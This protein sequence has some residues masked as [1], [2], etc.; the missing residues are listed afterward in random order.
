MPE[1]R[2]HFPVSNN[3]CVSAQRKLLITRISY[4]VKRQHAD[5]STRTG[6]DARR[7]SPTDTTPPGNRTGTDPSD[8]NCSER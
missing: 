5:A 4:N 7:E 3:A 6:A 2:L 1:N 8:S